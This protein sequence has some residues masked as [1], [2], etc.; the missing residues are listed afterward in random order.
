M[1]DIINIKNQ[2]NSNQIKFRYFIVCVYI[3]YEY[4]SLMVSTYYIAYII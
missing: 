1:L 4:T 2:R 3:K